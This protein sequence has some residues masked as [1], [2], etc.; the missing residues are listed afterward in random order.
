M[1]LQGNAVS[2]SATITRPSA[3]PTTETE[4]LA[5]I[6]RDILSATD[7]ILNGHD[8]TVTVAPG[9]DWALMAALTLCFNDCLNEPRPTGGGRWRRKSSS[10]DWEQED[11]PTSGQ[12]ESSPGVPGD[13]A[14]SR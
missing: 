13:Q 2:S 10:A 3:S 9:A 8:Y 12:H 6:K 7:M 4:T 14:A 1:K 5:E 11:G